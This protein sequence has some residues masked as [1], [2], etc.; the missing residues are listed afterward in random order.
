VIAQ[1]NGWDERDERD[2]TDAAHGG[3]YVR[4]RDAPARA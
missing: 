2:G 4:W 3:A 1:L